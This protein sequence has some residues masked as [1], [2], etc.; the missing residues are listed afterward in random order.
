MG[1]SRRERETTV[2][3]NEEEY[4]ASIWTCSPVMIRRLDRLCKDLPDF[5]RCVLVDDKAQAKR[6][7][8]PKKLIRFGKPIVRTEAQREAARERGKA[9][10]ARMMA[11]KAAKKADR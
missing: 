3:F 5:Y 4:T 9:N 1:Y 10:A 6:Y 7:E 2:I 8:V 11:A